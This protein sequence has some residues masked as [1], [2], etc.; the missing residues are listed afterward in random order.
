M[1]DFDLSGLTE[2]QKGLL[3]NL[4]KT[5][6]HAAADNTVTIAYSGGLDSRFL[7]FCAHHFGFA[8]RLL[9]VAGE[10]IAKQETDEAVAFAKGMGLT[11]DVVHI[12]LPTPQALASAQKRRCYVCKHTIFSQLKAF[13]QGGQLCDG[14][15]ASDT[16]VFRPGAQALKELG[17]HSPLM[18]AGIAKPDIRAIGKVLGFAHPEQVARPCLLTRFPYGVEP[19]AEKLSVIARVES[20]L[21][22]WPEAKN[23]RVRLRYPDGKTP[24]LHIE[25]ASLTDA[26]EAFLDNLK[27]RL[28]ETFGKDVEG[29]KLCVMDKLSGYYDRQETK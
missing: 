10:H 22:T 29:L 25:T 14:T 27:A 9:H 17:I 8:V 24:E 5:L 12:N 16:L 11:C 26:S 13:A 3:E 1:S 28:I 2:V 15:N 21:D 23:L 6:K 7:A 4:K 18:E 20:T 19:T